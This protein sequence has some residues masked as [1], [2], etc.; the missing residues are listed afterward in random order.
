MRIKIFTGL[1]LLLAAC[2]TAQIE[3]ATGGQTA[4]SPSPTA[5]PRPTSP[6]VPT[7]APTATPDP[8]AAPPRLIRAGQLQLATDIDAIPAIFAQPEFFLDAAAGSRE[9]GDDEFVIGVA[10]NG[11]AKAYPVR[12][13]SLHEIVNDEFGGQP[14]LVTWCPLCFS[15]I[16]FDPVVDGRPLTFGVSGY[17]YNDNLVMYDHQ[18]NTLW[19]QLLGQ[20][21]R[22]AMRRVQLRILPSIITS[23]G[24][25]KTVHPDTQILSAE[26]VGQA[27]ADIID[28][29]AGYYTS[30]AAGFSSGLDL[31]E[32]LPS[33]LLVIGLLAGDAT[34]AYPLETMRA[35]TLINDEV[36]VLAAL[37]LF[38]ARLE[39]VLAYNRQAAG[40]TLTFVWAETPGQ[41]MDA[42]TGT[43][44]DIFTGTAVSG[45]LVG[46]SLTQLSAPLVF[47]FAWAAIHPD[48]T[49]YG[50]E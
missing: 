47:W 4:V 21:V 24:E 49:I 44:W 11:V 16:A 22:G 19:S 28:P 38:D 46:E 37:L 15:A 9:W 35:E 43:K 14:V 50:A 25:W 8:L 10:V 7:L 29:Y 42:E 20:S 41:V 31:D 39:T 23:W 27:A 5:T 6:P 3:Q 48:T 33:K 2:Q 40:Q 30:G 13:L 34:R 1:L 26:K 32:R 17:L 18:T 12:L 36:G 45:P